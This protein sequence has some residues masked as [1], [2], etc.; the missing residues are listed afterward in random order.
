MTMTIGNP[1]SACLHSYTAK[2]QA[3]L[4]LPFLPY[5]TLRVE[6]CFDSGCLQKYMHTKQTVLDDCI[7]PHKTLEYSAPHS[8]DHITIL[9]IHKGY[10]AEL[11][12]VLFLNISY[13]VSR[14]LFVPEP[15]LLQNALCSRTHFVPFQNVPTRTPATTKSLLG[16]SSER[17]SRSKII[18]MIRSF[19]NTN[20]LT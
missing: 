5:S 12:H 1:K 16:P 9:C 7:K 10:E 20:G 13:S 3:A 17:C 2:T 6:Q 15:F 4:A 19:I 8:N 18:A 14:T 11:E